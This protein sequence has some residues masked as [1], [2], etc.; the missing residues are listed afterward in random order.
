[1]SLYDFFNTTILTLSLATILI[2]L[3]AFII[4]QVKKLNITNPSAGHGFKLES[5]F[6]RRYAPHIVE[7]IKQWEIEEEQKSRLKKW[8]IPKSAFALGTLFVLLVSVLF[9]TFFFGQ[10][11]KGYLESREIE[12][13]AKKI[14]DLKAMGLLKKYQ[15]IP[16]R[17]QSKVVPAPRV[18]YVESIKSQI[19]YLQK[20]KIF[21]IDGRNLEKDHSSHHN[22]ALISWSNFLSQLKI[23]YK[24]LK[25]SDSQKELE[26]NDINSA[27]I[28]IL[29]HVHHIP[30]KTLGRLKQLE[31]SGIKILFTGLVGD[32]NNSQVNQWLGIEY[33]KDYK[34]GRQIKT[35]LVSNMDSIWNMP[36]GMVVDFHL[37]NEHNLAFAMAKATP[38][39]FAVNTY[40]RK[41]EIEG[42]WATQAIQSDQSGLYWLAFNPVF[43]PLD[44]QTSLDINGDL[45]KTYI[46]TQFLSQILGRPQIT[47]SWWPD[48]APY[49]A[50][51]SVD[52]ESKFSNLIE[53]IEPLTSKNL[54]LSIFMVADM[55]EEYVKNEGAVE[56]VFE[57]GSHGD[58]HDSFLEQDKEKQFVRV[59][60]SRHII[61]EI[62]S[63]PVRGFRPP[64]EELNDD[65][66]KVIPLNRLQ[67][68]F[69]G[70]QCVQLSPCWLTNGTLLFPR[71]LKDDFTLIK[72]R[73]LVSPA[74]IVNAMKEDIQQA[75]V[76]GGGYFLSAHTQILGLD[77]YRPIFG[78][79][80]NYLTGVPEMRMITFV[81]LYE[82]WKARKDVRTHWVLRGK[83]GELTIK[84]QS[85]KIVKSMVFVFNNIAKNIEKN[86]SR[87]KCHRDKKNSICEIQKLNPA[88]EFKVNFLLEEDR[89]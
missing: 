43:E 69:A 44:K 11:G 74:N 20:K 33:S 41:I 13:R 61:E 78:K 70:Q 65:T 19:A 49:V 87:W 17:D 39:A 48:G 64:F 45:E 47:K 18:N 53:M 63:M 67:Y 88:E 7:K 27:D 80:A 12:S 1:M 68:I 3:V 55:Y 89:R 9:F 82:W 77:P 15:F 38:L 79:V 32:K 85:K 28:L 6:F 40:G 71:V 59:Q 16:T 50:V 60:N 10:A 42:K 66:L 8:S 83:K 57:V 86:D 36:P 14:E 84:N 51:M 56:G 21:L 62:S 25:L 58:N 4:Y 81:E 72:D 5:I 24:K 2:T 34:E 46:F 54:P 30:D 31:K 23:P 37:D 73:T 26:V 22:V 75:I 76:V 52:A 35:Q 29:P